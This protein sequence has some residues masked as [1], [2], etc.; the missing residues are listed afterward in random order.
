MLAIEQKK[1]RYF[2]NTNPAKFRWTPCTEACVGRMPDSQGD[3]RNV[4]SIACPYCLVLCLVRCGDTV[5]RAGRRN[6]RYRTAP[7]ENEL[8][9]EADGFAIHAWAPQSI[10]EAFEESMRLERNIPHNPFIR[11]NERRGPIF[12]TRPR[13]PLVN[14]TSFAG[15]AI[16]QQCQAKLPPIV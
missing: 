3:A 15:A 6:D 14:S 5:L 10:A 16:D 1:L 7:P 11:V 13:L 9:C 4:Q 8:L 2:R 12:R